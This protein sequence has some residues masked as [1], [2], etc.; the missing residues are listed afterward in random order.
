MKKI[1]I[2]IFYCCLI[3]A[4]SGCKKFLDEKPDAKLNIPSTLADFQALLDYYPVINNNGASSGEVSADN[5]YLL[6]AD[7]QA[8]TQDYQKN[9]YTW[10]KDNL[11]ALINNDWFYAYRPVFTSN[12]ILEGL[13]KIAPTAVNGSEYNNVKGEALYIRGKAFLKAIGLWSAA[14]DKTNATAQLGIPIR[15][16]SDFNQATVRSTQQESYDQII[17]DLTSAA[18]LLPITPLQV[19][20]PS[21]PAAYALLAR[22]YLYMGQ[23]DKAGLYADSC[24]QLNHT[25]IDFNSL[26][27][28]A[29][30]PFMKFNA[31]V[32][33]DGQMTNLAPIQNTR[34]RV[35]TLLYNS[36][37]SNDLRKE[38]FFKISINGTHVFKGSYEGGSSPFDG[39]A[40]DEVYLM[41]AECYARLNRTNE[42]LRDLNTLLVT[43]FKKGFFSPFI[44]TSSD[45]A[46]SIILTERRKELL[47]RG[48]RWNDLKRLNQNGANISLTRNV[49]GQAY[50]LKP[51]DLKYTLPIPDDIIQLTGMQQNPR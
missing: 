22:A 33:N 9:L 35:D 39:V 50:I 49:N 43:R 51:N 37:D 11:F 18:A 23:Y 3:I 8:L 24:L 15:L 31:E 41:R 4:I 7:F 1:N 6:D 40:I 16:S 20:R 2:I 14:Y 38:L 32:I 45:A 28:A 25:L 5:Y 17:S 19:L 48:L 46:L 47:M 21:K 42:A 34:A 29:A 13:G 10:Q 12:T 27:T 26:N 36:Y 30:Y 44:A